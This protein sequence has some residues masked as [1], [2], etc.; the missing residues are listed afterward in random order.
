LTLRVTATDADG[1]EVS[2][3]IPVCLG[4]DCPDPG[5]GDGDSGDGDGDPGDGD[6]ESGET[7]GDTAAADAGDD[8]KGCAIEQRGAGGLGGLLV[9]GLL[10][11]VRRRRDAARAGG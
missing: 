7:G 4:G 6:G 5:D 8:G 2:T 10:G 11:V 9:L 1:N 3:E